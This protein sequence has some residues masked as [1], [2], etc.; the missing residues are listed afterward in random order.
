[1]SA[2]AMRR[3]ASTVWA[4]SR[5]TS[6]A[7]REAHRAGPAR[8]VE[9][10]RAGG[11]L[12]G[13]DLLA[14]RRLRVA[15]GVGGLAEGARLGHRDEGLQ[16]PDLDVHAADRLSAALMTGVKGSPLLLLLATGAHAGMTLSDCPIC[17]RREL[18]GERSL[19]PFP[20]PRGRRARRSP[21]GAAAPCSAPAATACCAAPADRL[22]ALSSPGAARATSAPSPP[23]CPRSRWRRVAIRRPSC[24]ASLTV[25]R[26]VAELRG[27]PRRG[28]PP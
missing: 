10:R 6:P 9:H 12:E 23:T 3:V 22:P 7:G 11:A 24:T 1:M 17:G 25:P 28:R 5:S 26:C 27:Q 13:G 16:V 15:E 14:D 20:T 18:R 4:C 21:A 2:S 8:A 19:R